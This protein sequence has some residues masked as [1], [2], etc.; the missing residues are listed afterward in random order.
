MILLDM[1]HLRSHH[2]T[3]SRAT[4]FEN[5]KFRKQSTINYPWLG[6]KRN[7]DER[8]SMENVKNGKRWRPHVGLATFKHSPIFLIRRYFSPKT[9]NFVHIGKNRGS[10]SLLT[11]CRSENW[12]SKRLTDFNWS[13]LSVE[14]NENS[15]FQTDPKLFHPNHSKVLFL[16]LC[17]PSTS[18]W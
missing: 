16:I 1:L 10:F 13:Y 11:F 14:V 6:S 4:G 2:E 15:S 3:A 5:I 17:P 18:A 7:L 8:S 9:I 12:G